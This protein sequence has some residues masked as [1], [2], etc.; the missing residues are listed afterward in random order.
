MYVYLVVFVILSYLAWIRHIYFQHLRSLAKSLKRVMNVSTEREL[1]N[2]I[3]ALILTAH[4]DDECMFFAPTIIRLR[5]FNVGVHLLCLSEG[6][7]YNQGPERRHELL[8]SCAV[9]GIPNSRITIIDDER[10]PDDPKAEWS[11]A[12]ISSVV[13]KHLRAHTFNLVLTFDGSGV[14]GHANHVAIYTAIRYLVSTGEVPNECTF[15]SL[16]TVGLLRKYFSFLELPLSW[17]LPSHLCLLVGSKGYKQAKAAMLC[18]GSQL[19]WF[20]RLYIAF[21]RYM[22]V[23]TFQV[24]PRGPKIA[25]IY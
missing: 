21:S 10:L 17:L 7:Y 12:L 6:N 11:T 15:L 19:L 16:V 20:R 1:N 24:I 23:N 25:K 2:D 5:E 18:H 14:S 13:A 9:L 3:T 22:F 8:R 4:P